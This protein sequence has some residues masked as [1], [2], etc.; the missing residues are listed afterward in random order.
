MI[1]KALLIPAAIAGLLLI[2]INLLV[3]WLLNG[4][5]ASDDFTISLVAGALTALVVMLLF[6]NRDGGRLR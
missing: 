3:E 4:R 2:C 6:H 1:K 5:L